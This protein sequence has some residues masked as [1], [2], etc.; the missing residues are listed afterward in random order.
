[1]PRFGAPP[2]HLVGKNRYSVDDVGEVVL[3]VNAQLVLLIRIRVHDTGVGVVFAVHHDAQDVQHGD[4]YVSMD[5][6]LDDRLDVNHIFFFAVL[7]AEEAQ[8]PLPCRVG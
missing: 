1:M 2:T 6:A 5:V 7:E 3:R 8:E 4:I